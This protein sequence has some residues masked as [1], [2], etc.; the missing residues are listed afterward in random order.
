MAF[1]SSRK[2]GNTRNVSASATSREAVASNVLFAF[3]ISS[4]SAPWR[5]LIA[6]NTTP[7]F[8]TRRRTAISCWSS[9]FSSVAPST[10][11]PSKFPNASLRSWPRPP[12]IDA[13]SSFTHSW[14]AS[15]VGLSNALKISSS[16]TVSST[17]ELVSRPPSSRMSDERLP[18][19]SST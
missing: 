7:V 12:L 11:K 9:S 6:P 10:A 18:G 16:S 8:F 5:S 17:L 19:A 2:V 14:N 13:V 1:D 4:P 15:R 3:T